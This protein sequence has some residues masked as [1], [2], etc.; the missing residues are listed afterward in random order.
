MSPKP[1]HA[2]TISTILQICST[3]HC[4]RVVQPSGGLPTLPWLIGGKQF[5]NSLVRGRDK[6]GRRTKGR[7]DR[8]RKKNIANIKIYIVFLLLG[9]NS[10]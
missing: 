5:I 3:C 6:E 9:G 4:G 2:S 1:Q 10:N 7:C 8:G